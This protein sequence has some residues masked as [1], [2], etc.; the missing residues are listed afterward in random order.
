MHNPYKKK[1]IT[2]MIVNVV[3]SLL[4]LINTLPVSYGAVLAADE[5]NNGEQT[6]ENGE[7]QQTEG[8][9]NTPSEQNGV[10][11]QQEGEG[12]STPESGTPENSI[13]GLGG[14]NQAGGEN[15]ATDVV[16]TPETETNP[17]INQ[18]QGENKVEEQLT[19][20]TLSSQPMLL[21]T[22]SQE[23][24]PVE[25]GEEQTVVGTRIDLDPSMPVIDRD[26]DVTG[27]Y[28]KNQIV[29]LNYTFF[30][31]NDAWNISNVA[32]S[33]SEGC[34][35]SV[36]QSF[37]GNVLTLSISFG[38]EYHAGTVS[39][40]VTGR[41]EGRATVTKTLNISIP[42]LEGIDVI[43]K[44]VDGTVLETDRNVQVGTVP[45]YN[46]ETPTY[47][48][49]QYTYTFTGWDKDITAAVNENT[50]F[51][52]QYD[53][54]IKAYT[55]T[56]K[57]YDGTVLEVDENVLYGEYPEYNG[58]SPERE[59]DKDY[60]YGF[61]GWE[62]VEN[63]IEG[64]ITYIA[65]FDAY[66]RD[67]AIEYDPNADGVV[68]MPES[69]NVIYDES[70]KE[71]YLIKPETNPTL[72]GYTFVGWSSSY[73]SYYDYFEGNDKVVIDLST[74]VYAYWQENNAKRIIYINENAPSGRYRNS[75]FNNLPGSS[76]LTSI[77]KNGNSYDV[78]F[79][80]RQGIYDVNV[81]T[82]KAD[83]KPV[84]VKIVSGDGSKRNPY[85]LDILFE[86]T[87][88]FV[89]DDGTLIDKETY[90]E[91][92]RASNIY[93]P[94]PQKKAEAG[95][96]YTF[97]GWDK[98]ITDVNSNATYKATYTE[99]TVNY[100]IHFNA[101]AGEDAVTNMPVSANVV[102]DNE[103]KAHF[104]YPDEFP[105]RSGYE[106]MGWGIDSDGSDVFFSEYLNGNSVS[107][108]INE[109]TTYEVYALWHNES[110]I[111]ELTLDE[112]YNDGGSSSI[113][114]WWESGLTY[115]NYFS[116]NP[117]REDANFLG[118][119]TEAEGGTKVNWYDEFKKENH[120]LYA[121]WQ[122]KEYTINFVN[123]VGDEEVALDSV[124]AT[125]G[126]T[127]V[128]SGSTP[129]KESTEAGVVYEFAGWTNNKQDLTTVT[130]I[131]PATENATYYAVFNR[132]EQHLVTF[133]DGDE[134]LGTQ[135]V[136]DGGKVVL[137][138]DPGKYKY[139]FTGWTYE[140][141]TAFNSNTAITAD[142]VL[143]ASWKEIFTVTYMVD[144]TTYFTQYVLDGD[145]IENEPATNP[146][147]DGFKFDGWRIV[148]T[149]KVFD[150]TVKV[151]K[152]LII[153]P[154]WVEVYTVIFYDGEE[155]DSQFVTK[156]GKVAK[157]TN[158]TK[159]GYDFVAWVDVDGSEYN[160]NTPVTSNL[161]IEA[162][163]NVHEYT[164]T[165]VIDELTTLK[166]AKEKYT[167]EDDDFD[168]VEPTKDGYTFVAWKDVDN[169]A[170]TTIEN[171]SSGDIT[172]TAE[173]EA[174]TYTI[175]FHGN[176]ADVTPT[177]KTVEYDA[178]YGELPTPERV[179]Y[180][181]A[182]WKLGDTTITSESDV[183]ILKDS[184]VYAEWTEDDYVIT[185][186]GLEGTNFD[187]DN[188]P[189]P[190]SYKITTEAQLL[191]NPEKTGYTF[192]GWTEAEGETPKELVIIGG[193]ITGD[194]EFTANFVANTYTVTFDA[195][196]GTASRD[197]TVVTYD[198]K[199]KEAKWANATRT[200]YT[201]QGWFTDAVGG[202]RVKPSD[203]VKITEPTTLY[204]H[205]EI[206]TFT[207]SYEL[208]G[209]TLEIENQTNYTVEDEFTLNNPTKTG[210]T[211]T[212]WTGSNGDVPQIEVTISNA[213]G[214]KNYT[215]NFVANTYTVTFDANGGTPKESSRVVTY[216]GPLEDFKK[217]SRTGYE[218]KGWFT[219]AEGG[220]RVKGGDNKIVEFTEDITLYAHWEAVE[221][222]ITYLG[223]DGATLVEENP[224][225]YT[226]E[227]EFALNNPTKTGY[228]F[229][230]WKDADDKVV[231]GIK[232]GTTGNQTFT[233]TFEAN[234]YVVT[235]NANGG[236]CNTTAKNVTYDSEYGE[237]P[238][239]TRN[240]YTFAG[241]FTAA[242][243]G[244]RIQATDKVQITEAITLYAHW[245][246]VSYNITYS[247]L[248]GATVDENPATYTIETE[249]FTLNNP[250]K[251]GYKFVG[252]D[253]GSGNRQSK[254][255]INKGTYGNKSYTAVFE[256]NTVIVMLDANGGSVDRRYEQVKYDGTYANVPDASR[257][258]YIFRGW[259]TEAVSGD[260]IRR[261]DTVKVTE[262]AITLYAHWEVRNYDINYKELDDS[263]FESNN[264]NPSRYNI[265][266][267]T[268]TL[269]SPSKEGYEF[270]GWTGSNGD[271]PQMT[272]TI[273][274][275]STGNKT[276]RANFEVIEY[277]ATYVLGEGESIDGDTSFT[278]TIENYH[279]GKSIELNTNV[280]KYGY[281]FTGWR[282]VD[283]N[284]T[285]LISDTDHLSAKRR[286]IGNLTLYP[287]FTPNHFFIK[288]DANDGEG[289]MEPQEFVFDVPQTLTKNTFTRRGYTF[290][291]WSWEDGGV[292]SNFIDEQPNMMNLT[293]EPKGEVIFKARWEVI[294]Y[295]IEYTGLL[296]TD[297]IENNPEWYY[298]TSDAI[299]LNNPSRVGYTFTG[300]T[301]T[302]LTGKTMTVTIPTNSIGDRTY[303]ANFEANKYS[304]VFDANIEGAD[305]T[306]AALDATYDVTVNLPEIGYTKKNNDFVGWS[307]NA[308]GTGTTYADKAEIKNLTAKAGETV[309]LYAN[310][311]EFEYDDITS[312]STN[313]WTIGSNGSI[314]F[315]F[316]R[317]SSDDEKVTVDGQEV[318]KTYAA[319]L[320]AGSVVIVDGN[321][322]LSENDFIAKSGS[323][324]LTLKDSYLN[325]LNPGTHTLSVD[326]LDNGYRTTV[327]TQFIVRP[328]PVT[329]R[330]NVPMTGV[331]ADSLSVYRT[332]SL[333]TAL[334]VL[335]IIK[336][337]DK[338]KKDRY[339]DF[340]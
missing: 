210:Y 56:W 192:T 215:A 175:S 84:G 135:Y 288:Y 39:V 124:T 323:L 322:K 184:D 223:L 218:F 265:E 298:V 85:Q 201:F 28:L 15:N 284:G 22:A 90:F 165:Y 86:Y 263:D 93:V 315:T 241:W 177:Y 327:S 319:F 214:D 229:T 41:R 110:E 141:G 338:F 253:D 87:I 104:A 145:T 271:V 181:F 169:K 139:Y 115:K 226:V 285:Q 232:K 166:E 245:D 236:I 97:A 254:V 89:N 70:D 178:K 51:T 261:K 262:P 292:T 100:K 283:A 57:N 266:T 237:L 151:E 83:G 248:D 2:E 311:K 208:N 122:V 174:N 146:E 270:I 12:E 52:A 88:R 162:K 138:E 189:N 107:E 59:K 13:E 99:E 18:E 14:D 314:D 247:G 225:T 207:I 164:I 329:P 53:T 68:G 251:V 92:T 159:T 221:Y 75:N 65:Q 304:V 47:D 291:G 257:T 10:E 1:L 81:T 227:D 74:T 38:E 118:W 211:F 30:R 335:I 202:D 199:Y 11:Q 278:Y 234:E 82:S 127:P 320:A 334:G 220:D 31:E 156:D 313:N 16:T 282:V 328:K 67:H 293:G 126:T 274:K 105:E 20:Q 44:N 69:A 260:H 29:T 168:L 79:T 195:N 219:A 190:K 331:G 108:A 144:G 250:T 213:T 300:W 244:E 264:P 269:Q 142:I 185:Y 167:I 19:L 212:G 198:A 155:F 134:T 295:K 307:T 228:T 26:S 310:W 333:V 121:H 200:G 8:G 339:K 132:V 302:D 49:A 235:F 312:A 136:D 224:T 54:V 255:T 299:T 66:V 280:T 96:S 256:A 143:V 205:W 35:V 305:G 61:A 187:G 140:D 33:I 80:S 123:I 25:Q 197:N 194:K 258:G 240:G 273:E 324:I 34:N 60:E 91:G 294:E 252:W 161:Y 303:T 286:I 77:T 170:V 17:E 191:K 259:Y 279:K 193:G 152:E 296:D 113:R 242:E 76:V 188:N 46:G 101:N 71:W 337:K 149:D 112:N 231:T 50:E 55:V 289:T 290:E 154:A 272:V 153:V 306:M 148:D 114:V 45:E 129:E 249:T 150:K 98:T 172:L 301:G 111:Y 317:S 27:T 32:V 243:D 318:S 116:I 204:A 147:K 23:E 309:T 42:E 128:Y 36:G 180:R 40:A 316:K 239:P 109:E 117:Y 3:L 287:N 276:Y 332:M 137:P 222:T 163:F 102:Y 217:P 103:G 230:G 4:L 216:G 78:T 130:G 330:H 62:P 179:G 119:Y 157:P 267:E 183:K 336:E 238:T 106:F 275:G 325:K 7:G 48:D 196:G 24:T 120:T 63:Q 209:G 37:S 297:T 182:G 72:D 95:K 176:G 277:T 131:E 308:D 326:F 73:D 9:E 246:V 133:K 233:A 281:T 5:M 206:N 340:N 58:K 64:N 6:V 321:Q 268:F 160:F 186:K 125:Y 171:G 173:F 43:W 94:I 21:G 158:P 203:K